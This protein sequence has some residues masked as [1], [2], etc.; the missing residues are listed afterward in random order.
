MFCGSGGESQGIA[1]T[2][3]AAVDKAGKGVMAG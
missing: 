1:A 3:T 2:T